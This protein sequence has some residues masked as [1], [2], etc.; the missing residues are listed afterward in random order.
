[1]FSQFFV[2]SLRGDTILHKDCKC[3]PDPNRLLV[4]DLIQ[5][6]RS[7]VSYTLMAAVEPLNADTF[8]ELTY[9]VFDSS[10]RP[11]GGEA[12]IIQLDSGN[13]SRPGWHPEFLQRRT[14]TRLETLLCKQAILL[15]DNLFGR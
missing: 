12:H 9:V 15:L 10:Q 11:G 3:K 1:M 7:P 8:R 2:L 14:W 4:T 13:V 5:E 6:S